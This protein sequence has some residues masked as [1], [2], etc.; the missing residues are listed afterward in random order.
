MW[1]EGD[2]SVEL[3]DGKGDSLFF[4]GKGELVFGWEGGGGW[5]SGDERRGKG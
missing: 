4:W 5:M 2:E 3:G 1:E